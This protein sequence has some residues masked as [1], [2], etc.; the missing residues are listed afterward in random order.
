M[1]LPN[2]S[3]VGVGTTFATQ[4]VAGKEYPVGM[5]ADSD[6]HVVGTLP[7]FGLFIPPAP[8]G[9]GQV[10]FD[11]FTTTNPVRLRDLYAFVATD[12]AVTGTLGV[13]LDLF[14]TSAV[15][16][17]GTA[18]T[19]TASTSTT[20]PNF[21][22]WDGTTAIPS[23]VSARTVPTGGATSSQYLWPE[24]IFTEETNSASNL[25]QHFNLIPQLQAGQ[26]LNLPAGTGIKVV[27]GTVASVG[28]IGFI[29][30]FTVV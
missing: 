3:H 30:V 18:A 26:P 6:G 20:A 17:G 23:G 9:A 13:R 25:H 29:A 19:T 11:L 24:Y 7:A 14:R 16:T 10:Y 15:G 27:Q 2:D 28:N 22:A 5:M 8:V 1:A 21:M 4:F 12:V